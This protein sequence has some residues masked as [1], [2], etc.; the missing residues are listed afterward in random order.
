MMRRP[1]RWLLVW[2]VTAG[3]TVAVLVPPALASHYAK[4]VLARLTDGERQEL[5]SYEAV[6]D[7]FDQQTDKYWA[8]AVSKRKARQVKK[9]SGGTLTL[10]D[11]VLQQPPVYA[12]PEL[13]RKLS[14]K[15]AKLVRALD[16][17]AE[18]AKPKVLPGVPEM[19]SAA[20]QEYG[21][22]P[23]QVRESEFRRQF[24]REALAAGL[25]KGQVVRVYALE[26][27]GN[28]TY[29]LISGLNS[30]TGAG[31]PI[32]SAIGYVQLLHAN[33][34]DTLAQHGRV[35]VTRLSARAKDPAV[36]PERRRALVDKIVIL[37]HMMREAK[38]VGGSWQ[39][40]YD[41]GGSRKGLGIHALNL[42]IDAGPWLQVVKLNDLR[43]LA[44]KKGFGKV[45]GAQLEIMNLAGPASGM[46]MLT[47]LTRDVPT[48]NFFE[49]GGYERNGVVRGRTAGQLLAEMD[50][51]IDSWMDQPGVRELT[52][53]FDE[54]AQQ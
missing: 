50:E 43:R 45:T 38:A 52:A 48:A 26:T 12:G 8:V 17:K 4:T 34:V 18:P 16:P 37:K 47:P 10:D 14:A 27:S 32:S 41:F 15:L 5:A 9:R 54:L 21:F 29:G 35:L 36:P 31:K 3:M 40:H 46:E 7:F 51:R 24:V 49:R 42:D 1:F 33:S 23:E 22:I 6:R 53:L 19:L 44:E 28:G 30:R 2:L 20:E 39:E 25:S 13:S 11:Y